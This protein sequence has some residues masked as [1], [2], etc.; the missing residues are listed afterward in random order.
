MARA[1]SYVNESL[2]VSGSS[3]VAVLQR[4]QIAMRGIDDHVVTT[5]NPAVVQVARVHRG[6][7]GKKTQMLTVTAVAEPQRLIV[8]LAGQLES[9]HLQLLRGAIL[10][11]ST[12]QMLDVSVESF[13]PAAPAAQG[14]FVP[15]SEWFVGGAPQAAVAPPPPFGAGGPRGGA[16]PPNPA[17]PP[18]SPSIRAS[19]VPPPPPLYVAAPPVAPAVSSAPPPIN[20][21]G[22]APPSTAD[23]EAS[24][25]LMR[26]GAIAPTPIAAPT[27]QA[28]V[29]L[30]DGRRASLTGLLLLGRD[31][32]AKS[33]TD[34]AATLMAID[35]E[36]IS[37]TH[38]SLGRT[39]DDVWVEDRRSTNG[40]ILIDGVGRHVSLPAGERTLL[41]LPAALLVGDSTLNI[42]W[43]D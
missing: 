10:G 37:K 12:E 15:S 11:R 42:A 18:G 21:A 3:V 40:T 7:L 16:V 30:P 35:D 20:G 5:P 32:V 2:I 33:P 38:L 22:F 31:P 1:V 8:T 29:H 24:H 23:V 26:R 13:R 17:A 28:L 4:V 25:T 36:G 41:R 19:T 9:V 27:R 34:V 14:G 43:A 6:V 39:G